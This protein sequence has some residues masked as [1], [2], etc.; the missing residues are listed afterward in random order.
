MI[1]ALQDLIQNEAGLLSAFLVNDSITLLGIPLVI[2]VSKRIS[3]IGSS[4]HQRKRSL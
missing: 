3:S 4:F 2:H 1:K